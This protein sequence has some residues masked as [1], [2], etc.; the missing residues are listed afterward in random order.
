MTSWEVLVEIVFREMLL[1]LVREV[2]TVRRVD[3]R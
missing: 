1:K 2:L 3:R